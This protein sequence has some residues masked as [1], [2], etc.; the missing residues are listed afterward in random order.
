MAWLPFQKSVQ[1]VLSAK[2]KN[3]PEWAHVKCLEGMR[4]IGPSM[5][6]LHFFDVFHRSYNR[7]FKLSS[8]I[9]KPP[10][11]ISSGSFSSS[12]FY[13]G[14]GKKLPAVISNKNTIFFLQKLI[15]PFKT[16]RS[17]FFSFILAKFSCDR[18][19]KF[20]K[21][22][23]ILFN[24]WLCV[25]ENAQNEVFWPAFRC[26]QHPKYGQNTQQ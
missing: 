3:G 22:S 6:H 12:L 7:V 15:F 24:N 18:F 21:T 8:T 26:A 17:L 11:R 10:S 20:S 19:K 5:K 1:S 13:L 14:N 9:L 25:F 4:K 16:L 23:A 2:M